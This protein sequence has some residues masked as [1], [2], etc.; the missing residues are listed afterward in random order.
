ME[1]IL[2]VTALIAVLGEFGVLVE[3]ARPRGGR[4]RQQRQPPQ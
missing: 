4:T 2:L 1:G 3:A